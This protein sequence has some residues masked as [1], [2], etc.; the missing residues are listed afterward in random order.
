MVPSLNQLQLPPEIRAWEQDRVNGAAFL[1]REAVKL[2]AT[3]TASTHTATVDDVDADNQDDANPNIATSIAMLRPSMIP[4]VNVMNEFHR[5]VQVGENIEKVRDDLLHSFDEETAKCIELGIETIQNY[6][7][8]WQSKSLPAS[9]QTFVIG[10]FSR[11]STLKSIIGRCL[12]TSEQ[13]LRV[14]VVCSQSTPGNEGELMASDLDASWLPDEEFIQKIQQAKINLVLLGADCVLP[15][16][17]GVVNKV[18]T[19]SLSSICKQ[20]NVP[21]ICCTDRWK[22]W[23]DDYPPGLEDIFEL[24]PSDQIDH[25]IVP[26]G[27]KKPFRMQK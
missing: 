4:I 8:E 18:G 22:L 1:A 21:V 17:K 26:S 9:E 20:S 7:T 10:T 11:S 23:E 15:G 6:Y 24:V 12:H 19:A 13:T 2:A 27:C 16:D 3:H 14:K 5:R 25:V